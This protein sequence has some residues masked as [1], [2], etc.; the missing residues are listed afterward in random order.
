MAVAVFKALSSSVIQYNKGLAVSKI[1]ATDDF[2]TGNWSLEFDELAPH[3][4][5]L[6][7]GFTEDA[8]VVEFKDLKFG[9]ELR[10]G[11]NIK[12]YGVFPPY[13]IKYIRSDQPYL[14]V[15]R[16]FFRPETD[17]TLWLWCENNG[18]RFEQTF[19]FTTPIPAQPYPSWVWGGDQ[20]NAPVE[21][22]DD[23]NYYKWDE[24]TLSWVEVQLE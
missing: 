3:Y 5:D 10:Q 1:H 20:W 13:G 9:Y 7:V 8:P 17:Y 6:F 16:L 2:V 11:D 4:A 15:E 12:K 22:P 18:Q 24:D 19:D 23:G 21:M 14:V